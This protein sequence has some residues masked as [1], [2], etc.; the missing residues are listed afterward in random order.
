MQKA[1][2]A[3]VFVLTATF[4]L[5]GAPTL[6]RDGLEIRF[7]DQ[8]RTIVVA[9]Q[10]TGI[11]LDGGC[12]VAT[13]NGRRT[14]SSD[15]NVSC[16][17]RVRQTP[18]GSEV[19]LTVAGTIEISFA[20][21]EGPCLQCRL[22]GPSRLPVEFR[23]RVAAGQGMRPAIL[24]GEKESDRDVL[25]TRLGPAPVAYARSL[26]DPKHDI[27]MTAGPAG[28]AK[29]ELGETWELVAVPITAS[30]PFT[31]SVH[32]HY[33][34]D[35][36]G[37]QFYEPIRK[38]PLWPTA[39]V[40]AMT[41]Y[42]IQGWKGNPAQTKEWLLPQIDWVARHLLP[43]AETLVFQLDDNY[44]K[45]DD[46]YMRD[47]SDYI[48]S[49]GLIP[50][51]WFT[52]FMTAPKEEVQ[53]HPDWFVHDADGK[54]LDSFGGVSYGGN[55]TLNVTNPAA[56]RAWYGMWWEKASST[57]NFDFFKIDGQP[58]VIAAYQK[59]V[60]GGGLEGYRKGLQIGREIVG[61]EK[62]INGCWGIPLEAIGLLDGSRTGGDTGDN[63]HAMDVVLRW[64]FLNNVCWWCD[65]DAAA[66]LFCASVERVRLNA[67]ARALTGQQFL[68]DD[69]WTKV[70][71]EMRR[72][73]QLSFPTLDIRPVN[74]YRIEDWNRYDLFCLKIAK[75]GRAW[76]VVGLFNY[77]GRA[78]VKRLDLSRLRLESEKVHVFEYWTS[79]YLGV[80]EPSATI[81]RIV[82][83]YGGDLFAIVP[84]R[85]DRP[86]LISTSRHV[87]QGGLDLENIAWD[88]QESAWRVR[89]ASSHLV[90]RDPYVFA[91][92]AGPFGVGAGSS[93]NG[94]VASE[95]SGGLE[96]ATILPER[97]G[98][99][100]W[101]LPFEPRGGPSMAVLPSVCDVEPGAAG[102]LVVQNTGAERVSWK[103]QS[104]DPRISV[105]PNHGE[106]GPWPEQ[107]RLVLTCNTE[108]LEPGNIWTGYVVV[109]AAG[110]PGR[111][112]RA[113]VRTLV[114]TPENLALRAE[115]SASSIWGDGYEAARVNDGDGATRWNSRNGDTDGSWIEL[116]WTEM[117]SFDRIVIDECTDFGNRIQAWRL[118]AGAETLEEI[119]RGTQIGRHHTVVLPKAIEVKR[120]RLT[121]E[122][123]SV[124]PTLWEIEVCDWGK[125]RA[126][127][128]EKGRGS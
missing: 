46:R 101:T 7:D 113:A 16:R 6:S 81:T 117:V 89:G 63:P 24:S 43:Y 98:S 106:V 122:K 120:L 52:P 86:V 127:A 20:I 5:A 79:K 4:G 28:K 71:P 58:T 115:A 30:E 1:F 87:S 105:A 31:L 40:V 110:M 23:A 9:D 69:V 12:F 80:F 29:W 116:T 19:A 112:I 22:T 76:D 121:V 64:S 119:A 32:R 128:L 44:S 11:L 3:I 100:S 91:F 103:I 18:A 88:R 104:A 107:A 84:A 2:P 125:V 78:A 33:Y 48:R 45:T 85:E 15:P 75:A 25:T 70:P 8:N 73:W 36:L 67:Q 96:W 109:E 57:W 60:D 74:L 82:A 99:C 35:T 27:A 114:P 21:A 39:P 124:V 111:P 97:S 47:I 51:I 26:F 55:S 61:P 62:F 54:P 56:V 83:P 38:R 34:R 66:N 123:A 77:S 108:G 53:R 126:P 37:I 90:A 49:K 17:A 93:T 94:P 65:P 42:G 10:E 92:A 95:S 118:E 59:A 102:S 50:G 13:V 14:V 68:T 41:W 72:V